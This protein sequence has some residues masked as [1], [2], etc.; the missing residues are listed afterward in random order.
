MTLC[1]SCTERPPQGARVLGA[2]APRRAAGM[3]PAAAAPAMEKLGEGGRCPCKVLLELTADPPPPKGRGSSPWPHFTED[4]RGLRGSR[5]PAPGQAALGG[6]S[7]LMTGFCMAP[8]PVFS[9]KPLPPTLRPC[10]CLFFWPTRFS[11]TDQKQLLLCTTRTLAVRGS[12]W[13]ISPAEPQRQV[14]AKSTWEFSWSPA[15]PRPGARGGA[16]GAS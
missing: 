14:V 2:P 5:Q 7:R 3:R 15:R 1:T 16:S 12:K 9:L 4:T 10:F 13:S 6:R 11:V 8:E